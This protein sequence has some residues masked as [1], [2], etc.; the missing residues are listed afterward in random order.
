[1]LFVRCRLLAA[2][3]CAALMGGCLAWSA[4]MLVGFCP[5]AAGGLLDDERFRSVFAMVYVG[6]FSV[7][8]FVSL[9]AIASI[10]VIRRYGRVRV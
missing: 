10:L 6:F 1:R 8:F 7:L 9:F 2:L 4:S 5:Y 3:G